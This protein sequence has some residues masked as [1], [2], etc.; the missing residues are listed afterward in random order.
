M[1]FSRNKNLE[2]RVQEVFYWFDSLWF[3]NLTQATS[4]FKLKYCT[5]EKDVVLTILELA[6]PS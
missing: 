5:N 3:D 6:I 2:Q 4:H 1:V